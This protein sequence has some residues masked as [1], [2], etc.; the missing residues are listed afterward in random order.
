MYQPT[1]IFFVPFLKVGLYG[2]DYRIE[3]KKVFGIVQFMTIR[4]ARCEAAGCDA[5]AALGGSGGSAAAPP[6]K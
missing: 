4:T 5:I 1:V 2:S 6:R 3:A